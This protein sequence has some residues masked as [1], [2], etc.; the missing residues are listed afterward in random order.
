MIDDD[1]EK[2]SISQPKR[3]KRK[4]PPLLIYNAKTGLPATS[5]QF[6]N[7]LLP[8]VG[9]LPRDYEDLT[10]PKRDE[11]CSL[12]AQ[13]N[14]LVQ[15]CR[16]VGIDQNVVKKW[17]AYGEIRPGTVFAEFL[18]DLEAAE[19]TAEHEALQ[20]VHEAGKDPKYWGAA[21]WY[22]ER[23]H[24]DRWSIS[25]RINLLVKKEL[26]DFL[27]HLQ[28]CLPKEIFRIIVDVGL[29]SYAKAAAVQEVP[30]ES[31]PEAT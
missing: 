1:A 14:F 31:L 21:A 7:Q 26:E 22:L 8:E 6:T 13:G 11:I 24:P 25:S 17:L 30:I 10:K 23:K 29:A 19:A 5:D 12:V 4:Q 2:P 3:R 28:D 20:R 16:Q 27:R 18:R 15:A 9:R